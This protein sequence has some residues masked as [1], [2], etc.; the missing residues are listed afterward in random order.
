MMTNPQAPMPAWLYYFGVDDIDAAI[1][2]VGAAGG[3]IMHGPMDVPGGAHIV[4][5]TDPQNIYFA[6]VGPRRRD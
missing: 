4:H 2:R 6:L 3:K 1:E 5:A